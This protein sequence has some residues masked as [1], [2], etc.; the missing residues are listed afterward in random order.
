[1][2]QA[3][4]VNVCDCKGWV[5][6]WGVVCVCWGALLSSWSVE[7]EGEGQEMR[8]ERKGDMVGPS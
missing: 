4:G 5:G 2:F 3:E 1:M 6:G 8:P 7:C